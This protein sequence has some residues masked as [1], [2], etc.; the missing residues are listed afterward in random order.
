MEGHTVCAGFVNGDSSRL[1]TYSGTKEN[2]GGTKELVRGTS[3]VVSS[4][5]CE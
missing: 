1:H 4:L 5:S 2:E 3:S